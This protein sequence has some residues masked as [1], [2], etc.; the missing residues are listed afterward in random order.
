MK[1][2]QAVSTVS[3]LKTTNVS[4]TYFVPIIRK[5]IALIMGTEKVLE[6]LVVF[7]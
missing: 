6:T 4:G 7:N 3:L 2:S 5:I 1:S